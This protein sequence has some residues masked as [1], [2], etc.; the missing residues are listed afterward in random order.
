LRSP[1]FRGADD[2]SATQFRGKNVESRPIVMQARDR[3]VEA[4]Q[5]LV[6]T[7]CAA[8]SQE[9][10]V[11]RRAARVADELRRLSHKLR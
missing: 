6:E 7:T 3:D 1:S 9:K 5:K 2:K 4:S 11:C 8:C 10:I